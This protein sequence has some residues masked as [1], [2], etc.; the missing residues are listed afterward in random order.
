MRRQ[1][2]NI[3]AALLAATGALPSGAAALCSAPPT[4]AVQSANAVSDVSPEDILG[5]WDFGDG[6]SSPLNASHIALSPNGSQVALQMRR[7]DAATNRYCMALLIID[8]SGKK[9]PIVA[10]EGGDFIKARFSNRRLAGFPI[11]LPMPLTPRWSPE[12]NR[13]AYVR[14][15]GDQTRLW[16]AQAN[17]SGATPVTSGDL[18]IIDLQWSADGRRIYLAAD[19]NRVEAEKAIEQEGMSG[20]R[21][22]YRTWQAA[23]ALPFPPGRYPPAYYE[24]DPG[25]GEMSPLEAG[26]AK[27]AFGSQLPGIPAMSSLA[28][29]SEGGTAKAWAERAQPDQVRSPSRVHALVDGHE[30][31]CQSDVCVGELIGIWWTAPGELLF[32]RTEGPA[33]RSRL[34]LYKWHPRKGQ[35]ALL[36]RTE[37]LILGC[38]A[39]N[40]ELLCGYE[41][42]LDPRRLVA[43]SAKNGSISTVYEPNPDFG[44]HRFGRVERLTWRFEG[45][46][47]FGDLVL[48][49]GYSGGAKLPLVVVQ[50]SS[51]GFLRG[52]TGDEYPILP[53]AA[54]GFAVLSFQRP[55]DYASRLPARDQAEFS[56]HNVEG[57]ADRR[58]VLAALEAGVSQLVRRGLVDSRRIGITGLSDGASTVQFALLNSTMFR[59]AAVSSCC[60]DASNYNSAGE[61]YYRDLVNWGY[62]PRGKDGRDFWKL[63]SLVENA[64]KIAAPILMQL[65]DDEFRLALPAYHALEAAGKPVEIY[66]FP[67]EHHIKWQPAHRLAIYRRSIDWFSRW[68]RPAGGTTTPAAG[69]PP[70]PTSPRPRAP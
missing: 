61:E 68:L 64:E 18:P 59:A 20:F 48:P 52:G 44:R 57:W 32:L 38:Q 22:D 55:T 29:V 1:R 19:T 36:L 39:A 42:S 17:E 58:H 49:P 37:D 6:G 27:Q 54:A 67:D 31:A 45:G 13:I 51:R 10:D 56:R 35:P 60:E 50:Y 26:V 41:R 34:A 15:D 33:D 47:A 28:T 70:S 11:G 7:A 65:S 21:Y 24:V 8:R 43:I 2:R 69:A 3:L 66:V 25:T 9:A 46:E 23:R 16:I 53:L 14:R 12:G 63:Y 62:P 4:R 5:L 40:R 30:V